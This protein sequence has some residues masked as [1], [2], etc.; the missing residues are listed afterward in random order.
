MLIGE[1]R[2]VDRVALLKKITKLRLVDADWMVVI[3]ETLTGADYCNDVRSVVAHKPMR[4]EGG[5]MVFENVRT[6]KTL[7]AI[8]TYKC[9]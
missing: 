4:I 6:A 2:R 1:P 7:A 3:Q 5:S 9:T 8:Y